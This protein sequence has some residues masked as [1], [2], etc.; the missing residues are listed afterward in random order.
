MFRSIVFRAT[1]CN[2]EPL[3]CIN[4]EQAM[5]HSILFALMATVAFGGTVKAR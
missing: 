2:G 4:I 5:K 1:S 3:V